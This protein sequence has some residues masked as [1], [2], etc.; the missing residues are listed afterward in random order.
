[1]NEIKFNNDLYNGRLF[2]LIPYGSYFTYN[3][4]DKIYKK[5][6]IIDGHGGV[7][8][9]FCFSEDKIFYINPNEIVNEINIENKLI[10]EKIN[11]ILNELTNKHLKPFKELKLFN[12]FIAKNQMGQYQHDNTRVKISYNEKFN[13]LNIKTK[14]KDHIDDD[15]LVYVLDA[16]IELSF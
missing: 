9:A 3:G 13:S 12:F 15:D 4:V 16:S 5:V 10:D 6:R 11:S 2:H 14:I 1:M 7:A 8:A